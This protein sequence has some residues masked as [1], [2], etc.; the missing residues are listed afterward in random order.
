MRLAVYNYPDGDTYDGEW[1]DGKRN[2]KGSNRDSQNLGIIVSKDHT[3]YEGEFKDGV[4]HG[5]G[6]S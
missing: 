6:R 3:R 2:G 5:R 4:A 1:A